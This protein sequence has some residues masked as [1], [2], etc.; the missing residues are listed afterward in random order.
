MIR[1]LKD[2]S[3]QTLKVI[4]AVILM[5]GLFLIFSHCEL[6]VMAHDKETVDLELA[7]WEIFH[8]F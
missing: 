3:N 7:K 4:L 5:N 2:V 6:V 8:N 1:Y